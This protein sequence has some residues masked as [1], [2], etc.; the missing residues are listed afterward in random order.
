MKEMG[1]KSEVRTV[2]YRSY[3]GNV[4]KIAPNIINCNFKTT[5]PNTKWAT[6]ITQINTKGRKLYLSPILDIPNVEIIS[7]EISE[8]PDMAMV[9]RMLSAC[10]EKAIV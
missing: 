5:S 7:Y 9:M 3:K 8:H 2:R 4:G 10:Q 6:D 1:L